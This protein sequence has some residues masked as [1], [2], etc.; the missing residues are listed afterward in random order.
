[1]LFV[2]L[3]RIIETA[4]CLLGHPFCPRPLRVAIRKPVISVVSVPVRGGSELEGTVEILTLAALVHRRLPVSVSLPLSTGLF[5][6]DAQRPWRDVKK[7]GKFV[8]V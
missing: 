8:W 1:M 7:K 6:Q 2:R 3:C 4:F 5:N